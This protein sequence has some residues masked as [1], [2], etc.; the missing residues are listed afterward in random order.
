M[1]TPIKRGRKYD[2]VLDGARDVFLREGYEGA[3]VDTIARAA[4]VSKATLYSYFPDKKELFL[5]VA[6]MEC[7]RQADS[8]VLI[9]RDGASIEQALTEFARH[10]VLFVLTDFAQSVFRVCV[11][12][13][14]RFPD[15]AR[16]FY[17]SGPEKARDRLVALLKDAVACGELAIQ[18]IDLAADQ[19]AEL[20]KADLFF[21]RVFRVNDNPSEAEIDRII[22]GAVETFM[23]RFGAPVAAQTEQ[24]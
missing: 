12:E 9:A 10:M 22:H 5:E 21:K 23:A 13:S 4:G 16:T 18:D 15:L 1:Q 3:S 6:Q 24:A 20:C 11:A 7:L 8:A 19:F 14:E 17:R 2:Q